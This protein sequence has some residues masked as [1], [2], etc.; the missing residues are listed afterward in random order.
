LQTRV[1]DKLGNCQD[2]GSART[3]GNLLPS[4][5]IK[6]LTSSTRAAQAD[7]NKQNAL[8]CNGIGIMV[9]IKKE[10][11]VYNFCAGK[12]MNYPLKFPT[13]G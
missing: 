12:T 7:S 11:E 5:G 8:S 3:N 6:E 2:E 13:E 1:G 9:S 4:S 10:I